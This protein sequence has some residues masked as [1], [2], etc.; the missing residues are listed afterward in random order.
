MAIKVVFLTFYFEAWDALDEVWRIMAAD[1]RFDATVISIPRKL[2]GDQNFGDEEKVSSFLTDNGVPHL[3]LSDD[4][5][6]AEGQAMLR[7][8]Q[9]DYVFVNYPWRRNYPAAYRPEALAEFTRVSYVPYYSLALVNEPGETGVAGHVFEQR[10]HQV[11]SLIFTPDA[12]ELAAYAHTERGNAHVHLTGSPKIDHLL[13]LA[14]EG[15]T[16]W[17]IPAPTPGPSTLT[18]AGR[19]FRVVWAPH[20]SYDSGWL[21]FGLFAQMHLQMLKLVARHPD[22]DFV[23]RPHPFL[24]GT[25]VERGLLTQEQLDAWLEDWTDLPNTA[26]HTDGEY[27]ALFKATDLLLTDGISF[28][29]EYPIVTGRPTVFLEK[30]DHW[31]FSP[32]GELAA[33]ANIRLSDFDAFETLLDEI[34]TEGLPDYSEPIA[35]LRAAASPYPGKAAE[36]IV[37]IVAAD[38]A[39]GSPLVDPSR[40]KTLAW[41]FRPGRE[42][43]PE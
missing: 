38:H 37:A 31:A 24:F 15:V 22:I 30:A 14:N 5:D 40:L 4:L 35:R 18:G 10:T 7:R 39:A 28:L 34:R 3:R 6:P 21:N 13:R 36:R 23:L 1:P 12:A 32:L 2:T 33:A 16:D 41:E 42:P 20:H 19:R 8:L 27:A 26:I 25:L 9:P 17:P 29:G 43:Q 11:A